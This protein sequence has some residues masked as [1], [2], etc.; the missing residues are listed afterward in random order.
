MTL[1]FAGRR[2][3]A[4]RLNDFLYSKSALALG[5]RADPKSASFGLLGWS[6][7][8]S[9]GVYY[10]DDNARAILGTMAASVL[11]K[12][13]RWDDRLLESLLANL[14]TTGRLGFRGNRIEEADLQ[15]S[16]WRHYYE[17]EDTHYAP[18]YEAYLWACF[19]RA[20]DKTHFRPFLER[21]RTA[22]RMT[23]AA[24]PG[25]WRWTNGIQQERARM[26]LPLAWLVR[27]EDT[28]EHRAWLRRIATDMLVFQN[29]AGAI[30]EELGPEGHGSYWPP[31]SN[32][33][34]G[35]REAPLLQRNGDPV[36]DLL[37]TSEFALLG[38]HEAA[39]AT[40]EANYRSAEDRL[41]RFLCRIQ[42]H[43]IIHPELDGAW[44]R[45]FDSRRWEYWGSNAD[46]GWGAW[47][48]VSGWPQAWIPAVLQMRH[49]KTSLWDLTSGSRIGIHASR[50]IPL[51]LPASE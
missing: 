17:K 11:L 32:E 14:R 33:E 13:T 29:E 51:M 50:I 35:T 3:M 9:A 46:L 48:A 7:P 6:L 26:L 25:E 37:Y 12:E 19:L 39:E 10:G 16:G 24:Y 36:S 23:M 20:Y 18:H 34:Y 8:D 41:T 42:V 21:A 15:S 31:R 22:I 38:L 45:A 44:Y 4:T 28:P 30:R 40:G 27:L 47:S 43:S 2:D 49:L 5:S 1:A